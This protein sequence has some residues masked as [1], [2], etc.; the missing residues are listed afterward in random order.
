MNKESFIPIQRLP[1]HTGAVNAVT[2]DHSGDFVMTGGQDPTIRLFNCQTG[3]QVTGFGGHRWGVQSLSVSQDNQLLVSSGGHPDRSV[4]LWDIPNEKLL[5]RLQHLHT[6]RVDS[7][8]LHGTARLVASGSFDRSVC[9]WDMRSRTVAQRMEDA[10]DGVS[11][12]EMGETEIV[13]A[14]LDGH[15]RTYDARTQR[16]TT[17]R[18][19]SPVVCARIKDDRLVV[20]SMDNCVRILDRKTGETIKT[21]RGHQCGEYRIQCDLADDLAIS[22]SEDGGLWVWGTGD[23]NRLDAHTGMVTALRLNS[24]AGSCSRMCSADSNGHVILWN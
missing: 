18:I 1:G 4:Y 2:Y 19:G 13:A 6:Q 17:E 22:G 11:W 16:M 23:I 24:Q 21:F 9:V 20:G 8:S 14:S 12:V 15:I 5:R 3:H 10:G 7:V